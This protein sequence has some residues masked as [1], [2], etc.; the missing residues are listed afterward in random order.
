MQ[1]ELFKQST[2]TTADVELWLRQVPRFNDTTRKN[3][4]H[5]Y[6]RAYS[7]TDKI[8]VAKTNKLFNELCN[9]DKQN[10]S[11]PT[12][13]DHIKGY[14]SPVYKHGSPHIP[15]SMS[16]KIQRLSAVQKLSLNKSNAQK[17]LK[18]AA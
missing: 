10:L 12:L 6:I 17:S 1:Q 15:L 8:S 14:F 5:D 4:V 2:I 13:A 11:A 9:I 18:I 16:K 7:V 3:H